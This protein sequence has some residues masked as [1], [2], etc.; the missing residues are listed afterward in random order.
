MDIHF[1]WLYNSIGYKKLQLRKKDL[2]FI[3]CKKTTKFEN[4]FLTKLSGIFFFQ[5]VIAFFEY[6]NFNQ[7]LDI[8]KAMLSLMFGS[9]QQFVLLHR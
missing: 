2:K 8:S 9:L 5:I 4:L 3:Y 7:L 6:L 1:D